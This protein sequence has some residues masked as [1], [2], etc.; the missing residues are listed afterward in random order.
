LSG[1]AQHAQQHAGHSGDSSIF[2]EVASFLGQNKQNIAQQNVDQQ[3]RSRSI[4]RNSTFKANLSAAVNAHQQ[5]FG[6]GA[7]SNQQADPSSMGAAAAMQALKMFT[8]GGSGN[9][10]S[11]NSQNAFVGMAMSQASK[12]RAS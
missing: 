7:N 5:F 11:G 8:S 2:S 3:G 1:A 10:Q 4:N 6:G 9:T 12:V